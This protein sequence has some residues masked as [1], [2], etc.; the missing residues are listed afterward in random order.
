LR[1][2]KDENWMELRSTTFYDDRLKEVPN[3]LLTRWAAARRE[4]GWLALDDLAEIAQLPDAPLDGAE[5]AEGAKHCF[6]LEEWDLAR[7][8][9]LRPHLRFLAGFTPAQRQ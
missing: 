4:R 9:Q 1:W 3:R 6:G 2:K 8:P 7:D 5:M